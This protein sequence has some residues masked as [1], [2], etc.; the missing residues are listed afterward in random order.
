MS[1]KVTIISIAVAL[2]IYNSFSF[3]EGTHVLSQSSPSC[4]FS[5]N[6]TDPDCTNFKMT[7]CSFV[8]CVEYTTSGNDTYCSR[9]ET[10]FDLTWAGCTS[11]CCDP[12]V[13]YT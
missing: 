7:Q 13:S 12:S 4:I 9:Q 1:L 5:Y 8:V 3:C 11:R 6:Y 10:Q 2:L